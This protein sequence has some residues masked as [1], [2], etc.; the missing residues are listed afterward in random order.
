MVLTNLL[1]IISNF[2]V[3]L[4]SRQARQF[5]LAETTDA[6]SET[7]AP[8]EATTQP[9]AGNGPAVTV[10]TIIIDRDLLDEYIIKIKRAS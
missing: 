7:E 3:P 10:I 4:G 6:E 9:S 8:T 5:Q 2:A 1:T